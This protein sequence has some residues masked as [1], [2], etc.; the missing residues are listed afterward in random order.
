[1]GDTGGPDHWKDLGFSSSGCHENPW[2]D[3]GK[4]R[5]ML[6]HAFSGITLTAVLKK[7]CKG[8]LLII[9]PVWFYY[10]TEV[11]RDTR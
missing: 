1:M 5:G 4:R 2:K 6:F 8:L 10:S 7:F 9:H 11:W 3:S